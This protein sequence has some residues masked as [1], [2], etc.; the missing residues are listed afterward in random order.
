MFYLILFLVFIVIFIGTILIILAVHQSEIS[1]MIKNQ[2]EINSKVNNSLNDTGFKT[3]KKFVLNDIATYNKDDSCKKFMA[4]DNDNKKICLIDYEKGSV[5]VVDFNEILNYEIY[6]NSSNQTVGGNI[7]GLGA[8][9]FGAE[10]NGVCKD[11][12]IIIRLKR[13]DTSQICY[14]IISNTMLNL[15][16]NKSTQPYKKCISTLQEVVSFLEV[17]VSENTTKKD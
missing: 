15:G 4:V 14:D 8:G 17:V 1:N 9:F 6:E 7:G 12:K 10:T 13:Y 5:L 3:T 11:L 16:V 2:T